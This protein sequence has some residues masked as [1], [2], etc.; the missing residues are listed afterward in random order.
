MQLCS[1]RFAV[2]IA[3]IV[4][5][6]SSHVTQAADDTVPKGELIKFPFAESKIF[7]GTTRDVSVYV[8]KQYDPAKPA[9]VYVNQDGVQYNAPAV[10]DQLIH[11]GEMPITIGVK[12]AATRSARRCISVRLV[13]AC[14]TNWIILPTA[15]CAPTLVARN[16]KLPALS[17][18]PPTT[19]APAV[20]ATGAASP[21]IID[22]S[23]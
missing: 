17:T 2:W 12:T 15:D 14:D 1:L 5:A 3:A 7:P 22:S 21:V 23:T 8:P 20:F 18:V 16:V 13:W 19:A 11:K 6:V 4:V 10:F 9:C